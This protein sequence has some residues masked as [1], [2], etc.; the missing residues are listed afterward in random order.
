MEILIFIIP[1][2]LSVNTESNLYQNIFLSIKH[3]LAK[4]SQFSL[5]KKKI[6]IFFPLVNL[7]KM[8]RIE[9]TKLFFFYSECE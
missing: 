9:E 8:L 1:F 5:K 4:Y 3:F 2:Y 7:R 6:I